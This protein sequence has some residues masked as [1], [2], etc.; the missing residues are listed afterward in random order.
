[1]GRWLGAFAVISLSGFA[2]AACGDPAPTDA[3][4]DSGGV[5]VRTVMDTG[6]GTD[7]VDR[8]TSDRPAADV[9]PMGCGEGLGPC[10]PVTNTG[11]MM[12]EACA[13]GGGTT[14]CVAAGTGGWD[15]PCGMGM[16]ACREGFACLT[17][18]R[19]MT[20]RCVKLC[21]GAT[22]NDRCR[23]TTMGGRVGGACSITIGDA[24]GNP[25]SFMGCVQSANCDW[26]QQNCM[27][28][29]QSCIPV[30]D[31]GNTACRAS[32]PTA[33]GAVCGTGMPECIRGHLCV[34]PS[35]GPFA[36]RRICDPTVT[37]ATDGGGMFAMCPTGFMCGGVNML[38]MDFGICQPMM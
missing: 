6:G 34:G 31:R 16:P 10:N 3:G 12:G 27:V 2:L 17:N 9:R 36:C 15:S 29:T 32:G 21:C 30:D 7:A 38:P 37:A 13:L 23:D 28:A 1:M 35:G 24:M 18:D 8:P 4:G 20:F 33:E 19:G 5:D 11:C 26:R 25:L 14:Q 22:D